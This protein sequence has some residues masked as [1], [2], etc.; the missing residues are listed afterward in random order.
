LLDAA[1]L[2]GV[3]DKDEDRTVTEKDSDEESKE[4]EKLSVIGAE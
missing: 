1:K 3:D 2:V 4:E